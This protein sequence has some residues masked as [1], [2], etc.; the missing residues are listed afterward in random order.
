MKSY[1]LFAEVNLIQ[2]QYENLFYFTKNFEKNYNLKK[3]KKYYF[4]F[5]KS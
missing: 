2:S 5:M 4:V 1:I 3:K